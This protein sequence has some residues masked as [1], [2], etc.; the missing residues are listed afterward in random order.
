MNMHQSIRS[1]LVLAATVALPAALA[2]AQ[3][4]VKVTSSGT[5]AAQGGS[6]TYTVTR[7]GGAAVIAGG[8]GQDSS[9]TV[10]VITNKDDD[11]NQ[12]VEIRIEDGKMTVKCDGKE[13]PDSRIKHADGQVI[14][15]DENGDEIQKIGVGVIGH[16]F[17]ELHGGLLGWTSADPYHKALGGT[18]LFGRT[19]GVE[20]KVMLGIH[21]TEPGPALGKHLH[22]NPE[23]CVMISG[24]YKGLPADQAGI[25][26]YDIIVKI[27]GQ[28]PADREALR[29][30]L[31]DRQADENV[32]LSIIHEGKS[33]EIKVKLA[34]YDGKALAKAELMGDAGDNVIFSTFNSTDPAA[35]NIHK[36]YGLVSPD[37]QWQFTLPPQQPGEDQMRLRLLE[38]IQGMTAITKDSDDRLETLNNRMAELERLLQE[39][40]QKNAKNP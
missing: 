39:L 3:N 15:L 2:T 1:L 22:I 12:A 27:D 33:K 21:M 38:K 36:F 35:P 26:Q 11:T 5:P 37:G 10:T 25:V 28:S 34:A 4:A 19:D 9:R 23:E 8:G 6:G 24:V 32:T 17:G 13:V 18:A 14:I 20:P 31:E 30:A 16:G 40:V 29:K 7:R